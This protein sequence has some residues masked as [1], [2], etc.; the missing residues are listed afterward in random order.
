MHLYPNK[1]TLMKPGG[2]TDSEYMEALQV[3]TALCFIVWSI[4]AGVTAFIL[5]LSAWWIW[6]PIGL[7]ALPWLIPFIVFAI[8]ANWRVAKH[9]WHL[10]RTGRFQI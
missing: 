3:F 8:P 2:L 7:F 6:T 4:V 5:H 10:S 9:I 1:E